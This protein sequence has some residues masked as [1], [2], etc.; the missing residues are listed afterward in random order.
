MKNTFKIAMLLCLVVSMIFSTVACGPNITPIETGTTEESTNAATTPE[1][2]TPEA[3]TP[4]A[5]TPE[6]T[7]PEVTTPEATTPEE[8][9]PE[10]PTQ[11]KVTYLVKVV[12]INNNPLEGI[13]LVLCFGDEH[14]PLAATAANG[15][16]SINIVEKSYVVRVVRADGYQFDANIV[17]SFISDTRVSYITLAPIVVDNAPEMPEKVDLD[18]YTYRAY[19]RSNVSTGDPFADGNPAF[20]CE[21]FWV[22]P[23]EG[24]PEDALSYAVYRR[25]QDIEYDYNVNIR[26]IPQTINMVQELSRYIQN[27][28]RFDL[29]IILAKSAASAAT[30]NLL[31]DLNGLSDL[32]LNHEAYDQNS[33]RELQMGGKLYYLSG[34]MNISTL[35]SVA[36]TVV[37]LD[38]YEQYAESIIELF[39]G[40]PLYSNI[41]DVVR[42]GKWTLDTMLK[43][44][45]I[46]SVDADTADGDLG[47]SDS[48]EIGYF[49]YNESA[50]YYFYGAGGRITQMND[51][52]IP[53]FVIKEEQDLFDYLFD[54]FHPSTRTT[55]KYPHGFSG[56]RKTHFI[57]KA[58]TLFTDMTLWDVRSTLYS[59]TS[60]KYGLL[61]NPV[62]EAG[63]AYHSVVYFYNTV[64]LWAIP[65]NVENLET[66]KLMM[67]VMA[68]YSNI[69]REGSTM[70]GYYTRTLSFTIAPDPD[71]REVMNIIKG[72]T[73]YDIALLYDWGGW[74]SELAELWWRRDTN[75][76][77]SLVLL[78]PTAQE[79]LED[80]IEQFKNPEAD[81]VE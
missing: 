44:A 78:L 54:K 53:E 6:V 63:D 20:Y 65:N 9:T 57:S 33:I 56:D 22:N 70:D 19:V 60:F 59:Q 24:E 38:R 37:N 18:D 73:V 50:V 43:I 1:A 13:E 2:T 74:A 3:T 35:D 58:D 5:T 23:A 62:K 75:N 21:D 39:E 32:N 64:H 11:T 31:T 49:Q 71:A 25:N 67:D 69:K 14:T 7:T 29:T 4:E 80:T 51:E 27:G 30:K 68:A 10:V 28:D 40:N 55:A 12:D 46:A 76:H 81:P 45:A 61:P 52:G 66:A 41:Y 48:D 72:S 47:A 26:Q 15:Y 34:D 16:T 17:Y 77:G 36:P 79:Q 42:A 8:T